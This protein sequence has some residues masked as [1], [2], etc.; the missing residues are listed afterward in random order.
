MRSEHRHKGD[1]NDAFTG[2]RKV[3]IWKPGQRKR[4]KQRSHRRDR[5][6]AKRTRRDTDGGF[7]ASVFA[8]GFI[9]GLFDWW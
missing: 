3:M 9:D 7:W 1:E 5:R 4:A 6:V 2:W 8:E